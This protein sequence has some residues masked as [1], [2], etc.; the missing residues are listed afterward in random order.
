[1]NI[2]GTIKKA[3]IACVTGMVLLTPTITYATQ[4]ETMEQTEAIENTQTSNAQATEEET[5]E[6]QIPPQELDLGEYQTEMNIGD[7][8]LLTVTIL[9]MNTTATELSYSSS[10]TK[11]ATINGMGR[12]TALK[13]GKTQIIVSCQNITESFELTVKEA[14]STQIEVTELDLGDC[15]EEIVV[16]TSQILSVA[17]IPENATN[18][19]L[20][21]ESDNPK[22]AS[23]NALGRLTAHTLG[24]AKI[25][26][27]CG[28][29][30]Q[31][32]QVKVVEDETKV[33]V[34]DI[35]ISDYE[36]ELNVDSILNLS[37]TILPKDATD[38]DVTYQSSNPQIATVN[39]SGEVKGIAPGEVTI[40]ISAGK[41]TKQAKIKV[42]IATKAISLNSDYQ[43][44][45][46]N[47]T[48]QIKAQVHPADASGKLTYKSL[49]VEVAEVSSAG[50]IT[51]KASGNTAIIVSNGDLQASV[52]IM[53]NEESVS[54]NTA[55]GNE[56][57]NTEQE[58]DFPDTV[59][60]KEYPVISTQMLKYFYEKE[61]VLTIQGE[62]YT[63]FLDGKDIVNFE[64]ELKTEL[65]SQDEENGF[66]LIINDSKK[67][68]GKITLDISKKIT[69]EKYLY[70]YNKEK[71]KYQ[72]LKTEDI[73]LLHINTEG[74]YLITS[75]Q[76]VGLQT[77]VIL[78]AIGCVVIMLGIG[79][80]IG[81][82][83]Q[84][85]FW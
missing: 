84:Y 13:K 4:N 22:V 66:T 9:P 23:V 2:K 35:E 70:L 19:V 48:F 65:T 42:K 71:G 5:A 27:S 38:T 12:I 3:V 73:S 57:I 59:N 18:K 15:P 25:T 20:E 76:V 67:L 46:P 37:V 28:K 8:Q 44:M 64:N 6:E 21:Y 78:I 81:V 34:T 41:V 77:N 16:G 11:V 43:V 45:K 29:V 60:V 69:D 53:V 26:V 68:C 72:N 74:K 36:D 63:I 7:K 14:Q 47:D 50:K 17:V 24:T 54:V 10:N 75:K 40:S 85:W 55:K 82:K 61:K 83:K 58:T 79:I 80:Y 30:K 31:V 52:N 51:A 62:D 49:D 33:E 1:M 39:S 56:P 32:F